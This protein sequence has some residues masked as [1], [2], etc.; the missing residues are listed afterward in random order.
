MLRRRFRGANHSR[1][2]FWLF[3]FRIHISD[4]DVNNGSPRPGGRQPGPLPS[5]LFAGQPV[6]PDTAREKAADQPYRAV[7]AGNAIVVLTD[8]PGSAI[9]IGAPSLRTRRGAGTDTGNP[10][11]PDE[12][13]TAGLDYLGSVV[14]QGFC[15]LIAEAWRGGFVHRCAGKEPR[16]GRCARS[17]SAVRFR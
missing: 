15:E 7:K 8:G 3:V 5:T 4:A 14:R 17:S 2:H 16:T 12:V 9:P 11:D 1:D 13:R 10:P 6:D